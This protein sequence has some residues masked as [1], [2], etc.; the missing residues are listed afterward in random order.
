MGRFSGGL[1]GF[2]VVVDE[3]TEGFEDAD[4][5]GRGH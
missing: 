4:D 5:G 3:A 2:A 1:P